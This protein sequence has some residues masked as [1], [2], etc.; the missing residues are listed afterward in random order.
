MASVVTEHMLLL[1]PMMMV[2]MI[3]PMVAGF[4]VNNFNNEQRLLAVEQASAKLGS[5]IQQVYLV[6]S[7]D[8]VKDSVVTLT[9]PLPKSLET[10][11]YIVTGTQEGESL[12]LHIGLPGINLWYDHKITLG[13]NAVWD[14]A[15]RLDSNSPTT[16][17]VARKISGKIYLSFG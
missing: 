8:N 4:V 16:G 5:A 12:T 1:V 9:N 3:F 17:I 13:Q 10:Q 11:Q 15:S 7:N 2:V 6:T 14:P